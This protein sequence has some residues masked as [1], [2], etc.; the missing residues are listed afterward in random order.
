[1]AT[2]MV[3]NTATDVVMDMGCTWYGMP[4]SSSGRG[5]SSRHQEDSAEW[6]VCMTWR[7]SLVGSVVRGSTA[8]SES[9]VHWCSMC[10][11]TEE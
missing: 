11:R 3:M 6:W 7:C 8:G 10:C 9:D 4:L 5:R 1:M 2:D